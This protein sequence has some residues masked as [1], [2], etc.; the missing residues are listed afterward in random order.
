MLAGFASKKITP[1]LPCRLAGYSKMR[2]ASDQLDDLYAKAVVFQIHDENFVLI[3]LD[4]IGFDNTLL[5]PL[6][7]KLSRLGFNEDHI[8]ACA[9]HTHSG[10]VGLLKTNTQI[11]KGTEEIFGTDD[12]AFAST[13]AG[14]IFECVQEAMEAI[15]PTD[16]FYINTTIDNLGSNRCDPSL[17]A[18]NK[19]SV[20]ELVQ[21]DKKAL[22][23]FSA[24]HATTLQA[25]NLS[26]SGDY[27]SAADAMLKKDGYEFMAFLNGACADVSTR[28][29]RV[30]RGYP[31]TLM[32]A[33]TLYDRICEVL[34]QARPLDIDSIQTGRLNF[35]LKRKEP[36]SIQEAAMELARAREELSAIKETHPDQG[37]LRR[38]ESIAEGA[39]CAL[40]YS[41]N[42]QE[43]FEPVE[44]LS[45]PLVKAGD[46]Y[47]AGIPGELGSSLGQDKDHDFLSVC[48]ANGYKGYFTDLHSYDEGYYES[49]SSP[50]QKGESEKLMDAVKQALFAMK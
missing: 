23:V 41:Y 31:Q 39:E 18:P 8:F 19:L 5:D 33:K 2:I 30:T 17:P 47:L 13:M 49:S 32:T 1:A 10:L 43:D 45:I 20:L 24:C 16:L 14:Q 9:T 11:L 40:E 38:Y 44:H 46:L 29:T 21:E 36:M 7:E 48:Y 12:D 3:N 25:D 27:C 22:I 28:Y 4:L 26:V 42:N 37:T 6:Y 15:A 34:P 35:D 50:F